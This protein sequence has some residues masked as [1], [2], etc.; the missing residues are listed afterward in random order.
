MTKALTI[1]EFCALEGISRAHWY[2]MKSRGETPT[3]YKVGS[4]SHRISPEAYTAYRLARGA[5]AP[6][7]L[8]AV[9]RA[10]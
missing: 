8:E 5:V 3:T 10:K 2:N 6:R 9:A 1:A 4:K 7:S